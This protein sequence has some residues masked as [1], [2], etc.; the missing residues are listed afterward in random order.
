MTTSSIQAM[1]LLA[2]AAREIIRA[3][4]PGLIG[5]IQKHGPAQ[6][7]QAQLQSLT[8]A[9]QALTVV[10]MLNLFKQQGVVCGVAVTHIWENYVREERLW[11]HY[12]GGKSKFMQDVYFSDFVEPTIKAAK[13]SE[14]YKAKQRA[15]I[16]EAWGH[17][18]E[19]KIDKHTDHPSSLSEKYLRGMA[20]LAGNGI[21]LPIAE[22]LLHEVMTARVLHPRRGIRSRRAIVPSDIQTVVDAVNVVSEHYNLE[23][24]NCSLIQL[25][26]YLDHGITDVPVAVPETRQI[27]QNSDSPSVLP[28]A[29]GAQPA[30]VEVFY[31]VNFP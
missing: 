22:P 14:K 5:A 28:L 11:E 19:K 24:K 29:S 26:S 27:P 23:P 12:E 8:L 20:K 30:A 9:D 13:V 1:P 6:T 18:W 16:E 7:I 15:C 4:I 3:E 2:S 10:D 21:T 25:T 31:Y 17:G